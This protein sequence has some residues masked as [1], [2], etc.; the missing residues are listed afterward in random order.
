MT[1][2]VDQGG[3][4]WLR[5]HRPRRGHA[6][7]GA[8]DACR[9]GGRAAA[10]GDTTRG[11]VDRRGPKHHRPRIVAMKLG[12]T[13]GKSPFFMGKSTINGDLP[14]GKLT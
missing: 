6:R 9:G 2:S 10:G 4:Y 13:M 8:S 7:S 14:S 12:F 5:H 1:T 11:G 3:P